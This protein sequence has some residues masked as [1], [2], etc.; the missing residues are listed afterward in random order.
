[1]MIRN[2]NVITAS[3]KKQA[4]TAYAPGEWF[5]Y[6]LAANPEPVVNPA[7]PL[8]IT[9]SMPEARMAPANWLMT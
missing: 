1:M 2:M 9:Y 4:P 8:A 5:P 7:L 6:P 3:I